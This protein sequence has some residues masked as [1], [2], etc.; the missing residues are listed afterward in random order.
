LEKPSLEASVVVQQIQALFD[1]RLE[2]GGQ[3]QMIG[4]SLRIEVDSKV[5][6]LDQVAL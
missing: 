3:D 2:S 6:V 4:K 5:V 1:T